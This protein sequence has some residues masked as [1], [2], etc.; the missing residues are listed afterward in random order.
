MN[1]SSTFM[2]QQEKAQDH[3][4]RFVKWRSDLRQYWD[5]IQKNREMYQFYKSES[6]IT[7]SEVSL[8]S[9]FAIIESLVAKQNEAS[10]EINT[11]ARG[12][13]DVYIKKIEQFISDALR[14]AIEDPDIAS[15]YGSFRKFRETSFRHL[16]IDGNVAA[17]MKYAYNKDDEIDNPYPC[18]LSLF[19]VIF[20][21]TKTLATSNEYY[22]EKY[23]TYDELKKGEYNSNTKSG[24]YKNL[25]KLRQAIKDD[26][27]DI[28]DVEDRMIAG[29]KTLPRKVSEIH[30]LEH[31]KGSK[32][33][34]VANGK[35]IV[36]ESSDPYKTGKNPFVF[37]MLYSVEGRPYAY[38]KIDSIYKVVRAQDTIIN[39]NIESI[40]RFLRPTILVRNSDTDLYMMQDIIQNGGIGYGDPQNVSELVRTPPPGAA[41]QATNEMQQAV[42]RAALYSPY[43]SGATSQSTDK[44]KGTASGI[45][46]L[47]Q[48][49]EPNFQ[50]LLDN[51]QDSIIEPL[52]QKYLG[53][54][55]GLMDEKDIRWVITTNE[56]PE[57]IKTTKNVL[58]GK[59]T[60][61]DLKSLGIINEEQFFE[62]THTLE[63]N[64]L[65]GQL[66]IQ[67]LDNEDKDF[68]FDTK[69][70]V[71]VRMTN[72]ATNK[73]QQRLNDI[74]N[75]AQFAQASGVPV[76]M[77]KVVVTL[78]NRIDD[79]NPDDYMLEKSQMQQGMPQGMS[80]Q[81]L[82]QQPGSMPQAPMPQGMMPQV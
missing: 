8:N 76:D 26:Y 12:V 46:A 31:W 39:Q 47:I 51:Y 82:P 10:L 1:E 14:S 28:P 71:K 69:W 60:L 27:K 48:E 21:P 56:N 6:S 50:I 37:G 80:A 34:V 77:K 40:N 64:V 78:G 33:T 29:D 36:R 61:T 59:A 23:V 57:W 22:V 5:Q 41:F 43:A 70:L 68:V 13:N 24:L 63:P 75:W 20:N 18:L 17:E 74:S 58:M 35:I 4:N 73:K 16:L 30:L 32:L 3:Y 11:S 7:D 62:L 54:I 38:G 79:F 2:S 19:S 49:S 55:A 67:P 9:P 65:T 45:N 52:L 53:V 72:N 25:S 42:E 66:E 15:Q 81:P 44:T